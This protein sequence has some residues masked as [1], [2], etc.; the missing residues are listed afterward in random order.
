MLQIKEIGSDLL[1]FDAL[2]K[3]Q[4]EFKVPKYNWIFDPRS[5]DQLVKNDVLEDHVMEESEFYQLCA[6]AKDCEKNLR[7]DG[8]QP[9]VSKSQRFEDVEMK[10]EEGVFKFQLQEMPVI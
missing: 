5:V 3:T 8:N 4:Q 9:H 1:L 7:A 6:K 2:L 10:A